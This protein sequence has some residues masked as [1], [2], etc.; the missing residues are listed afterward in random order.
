[1]KYDNHILWAFC[2]IELRDFD[3]QIWWT[4]LTDANDAC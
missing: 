3:E 4:E 1:M 2:L